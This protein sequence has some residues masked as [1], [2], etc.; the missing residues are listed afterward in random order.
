MQINHLDALAI[1]PQFVHQL[2]NLD[3]NAKPR[4]LPKTKFSEYERA[5]APKLLL[6]G[7][8]EPNMLARFREWLWP[9]TKAP[10]DTP[11]V[12]IMDSPGGTVM[13]T[14][15]TTE[16]VRRVAAQRPVIVIVEGL[17]CSAAYMIASPATR[18]IA[19]RSSLIGSCGTIIALLDDVEA[20]KMLG[21]KFVYVSS[22]PAK[23]VGCPGKEVTEADIALA[24]LRVSSLNNLFEVALLKSPRLDENQAIEA[25]KAHIYTAKEAKRLGLVDDVML[26]EEA[27]E[28]IDGA[29]VDRFERLTGGRA[30]AKLNRL[31]AES[32]GLV[33]HWAAPQPII[34]RVRAEY[35]QLAAAADAHRSWR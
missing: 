29:V 4:R 7:P 8:V 16:V 27:L 19:T 12:I 23:Q 17:C 35:P 6:D 14:D 18:I 33:S 11:L 24:K 26:A 21:L 31:V 5:V 30:V 22:A 34:D 25:L 3:P 1:A 28:Q 2:A 20:F 13:G 10:S 32:A 15:E 9:F